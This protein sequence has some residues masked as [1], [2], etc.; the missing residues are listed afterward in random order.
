MFKHTPGPWHFDDHA[1]R[2]ETTAGRNILDM[3]PRSEHFSTKE[4]DANA[5]LIAAAPELLEALEH[6]LGRME[7]SGNWDDG[8]FYYSRMAA[9]ELQEVI[10]K[11]RKVV[12]K[13]TGQSE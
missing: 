3:I 4:R 11:A 9:P 5:R 8:C 6:F 13:A 1:N 10:L 12:K 7:L 2:I